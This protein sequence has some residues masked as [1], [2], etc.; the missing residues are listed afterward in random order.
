MSNITE[1]FPESNDAADAEP[2]FDYLIRTKDGVEHTVQGYLVVNSLF[3]AICQGEGVIHWLKPFDTIE[4]VD[5]IGPANT[6][7]LN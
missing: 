1:L 4:Q 6:G 2:R 3:A 7:A 5:M